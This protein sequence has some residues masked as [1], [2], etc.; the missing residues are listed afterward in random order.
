MNDIDLSYLAGLFDGEGNIHIVKP[1]GRTYINI[2]VRVTNTNPVV[3]SLFSDLVEG[4][5]YIE[6]P[7]RN[8]KTLHRIEYSKLQHIIQVLEAIYPHLHLKKHHA[9]LAIKYCTSRLSHPRASY[10]D[11]ELQM[12][13]E[14]RGLNRRGK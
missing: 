9:E 13:R 3:V 8:W 4:H 2:L 7:R 11:A 12:I 14:L 10:D 5:H 6:S 1:H